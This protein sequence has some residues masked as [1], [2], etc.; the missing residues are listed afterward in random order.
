MGAYIPGS[1]KRDGH[2]E[3]DLGTALP[4][5]APGLSPVLH[6]LHS[7]ERRRCADT[8]AAPLAVF[9][10]SLECLGGLVAVDIVAW[11]ATST[12]ES[13]P[14]DVPLSMLFERSQSYW[15]GLLL[16]LTFSALAEATF[17][18]RPLAH[19]RDVRFG[20]R[21]LSDFSGRSSVRRRMVCRTRLFPHFGDARADDPAFRNRFSLCAPRSFRDGGKSRTGN[22]T[23]D[24]G[25]IIGLN[26]ARDESASG[27]HRHERR[28]SYALDNPPDAGFRRS[29]GLARANSQRGLSGPRPHRHHTIDGQEGWT[30]SDP[31]DLNDLVRDVLALTERDLQRSHISV[32]LQLDEHLPWTKGDRVQLQQVLINLITNAIDAMANQKWPRILRITSAIEGPSSVV[33][34]GLGDLPIDHRGARRP[35]PGIGRCRRRRGISIRAAG[36]HRPIGQTANVDSGCQSFARMRTGSGF[37]LRDGLFNFIQTPSVNGR[38]PIATTTWRRN[39]GIGG[40]NQ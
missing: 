26:R 3:H 9:C 32:E 12:S 1:V 2:D 35:P 24:D 14:R 19:G 23:D 37:C 22:A 11:F 4:D 33:G 5:L 13:M 28:R 39:L 38:T 18:T 8:L 29:E 25:R 27:E 30:Q 16:L 31:L 7:S 10:R 6:L 40:S 17:R 34:H 21:T 36:Q 15:N 20:D